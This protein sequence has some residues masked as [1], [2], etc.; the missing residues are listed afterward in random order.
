MEPKM[1]LH[2]KDE[3]QIA[4]PAKNVVKEADSDKH[5]SLLRRKLERF[6]VQVPAKYSK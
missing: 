6:I 3:L 4:W 1:K 5:T 2:S